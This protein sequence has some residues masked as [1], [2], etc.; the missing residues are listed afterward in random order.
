MYSN[1]AANIRFLD[2]PKLK[3]K[4]IIWILISKHCNRIYSYKRKSSWPDLEAAIHQAQEFS[5]NL[6]ASHLSFQLWD[7][8]SI[9]LCHIVSRIAKHPKRIARWFSTSSWFDIFEVKTIETC[10]ISSHIPISCPRLY[11]RVCFC[12]WLNTPRLIPS[13]AKRQS[14]DSQGSKR[15]RT[16]RSAFRRA[17]CVPLFRLQ[18]T[19]LV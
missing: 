2:T 5:A 3:C 17:H 19:G 12:T 7:D 10:T 13:P 1:S 6:T 9:F 16:S 4:A 8:R 15:Y 11:D 14:A 18:Y